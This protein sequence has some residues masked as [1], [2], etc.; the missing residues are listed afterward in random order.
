MLW[1][2]FFVSGVGLMGPRRGRAPAVRRRRPLLYLPVWVLRAVFV[3][4]EPPENYY[5]IRA[6]EALDTEI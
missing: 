4:V 1:V 5:E 3:W 6:V 2:I